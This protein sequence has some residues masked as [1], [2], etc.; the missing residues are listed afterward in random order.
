MNFIFH[1]LEPIAE[2][3]IQ[4]IK[5]VT[6]NKITLPVKIKDAPNDYIMGMEY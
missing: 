3:I 2:S 4:K 6:S 1:E 5:V